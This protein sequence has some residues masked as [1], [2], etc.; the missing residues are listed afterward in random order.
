MIRGRVTADREAIIELDI[1]GPSQEFQRIEAAIDTAYNGYLTL[2]GRLIA[3]LQLPFAGH[4]RGTLADGSALLLD[5]YLATVI[6]HGKRQEVLISK[7][8]GEPLVGMSL[9]RGSR[10]AIDVVDGGDVVIEEL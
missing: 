5:V 7:A 4:R 10:L 6:W 9:L 1:A 8:E 2:P 3:E